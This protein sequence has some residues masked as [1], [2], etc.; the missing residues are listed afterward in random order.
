LATILIRVDASE[1]IGMGHLMRCLD[2]ANHASKKGVNPV[3]LTNTSSAKEIIDAKGFK[4]III[5]K[6]Y[7]HAFK[8][9]K[10]LKNNH[11]AKVIL[12]DI[13]Y[14]STIDQ[15]HEYFDFLQELKTL[16]L[17]L[18]T[19][20]DLSSDV[21][22]ADIVIIP[23]VGGELLK[24]Q[25]KVGPQ[26]LLGTK[27]FPVREEFLNVT[28]K[29]SPQNVKNILITMGGSDP[30]QITTKVVKT[31]A[32]LKYNAHL[33]IVLGSFSQISDEQIQ[34]L[35]NNYTGSFQ[36]I[37]DVQ[38][39][40]ELMNKSQLAITNSGLTKYEMAS[41][42][43]PAIV[44]SNNDKHADLMDDFA[45]YG[46]L[47]HLGANEEVTEETILGAVTKLIK[48]EI[49]RGKMSNAG[50]QLVDGKGMERIFDSIPGEMIYA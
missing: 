12:F 34:A 29:Q 8:E 10:S 28:K 33:K 22:P 44:I 20:E 6:N 37:R 18:I 48:D 32:K 39:M 30:N 23:Y 24:F 41:M 19:F 27:F 50:K 40:A 36:V 49:N 35:L 45:N 15:R 16:D 31:L 2:F 21:F 46:T 38:N 42:G 17:F 13:N 43:L 3:F 4:C 25:K 11:S 9:I 26:Y 5:A 47:V 7:K 1:H 14:C